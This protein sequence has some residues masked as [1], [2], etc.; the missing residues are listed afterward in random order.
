MSGM[1]GLGT[2]GSWTVRGPLFVAVLL[3]APSHLAH[4]DPLFEE[5][6]ERLGSPQPCFD[7]EH[8][9]AE[10]CYSSYVVAA[11]LNGDG[12]LDLLFANGGGYFVPA[13]AAPLAFYIN[14][15]HGLFTEAGA[16]S[17]GGFS[18]RVRQVAVGDIDGDG[19]LDVFV[20]DAFGMQAS[21]LFLNDG[22]R[23]P[24]FVDEAAARLPPHMRASAA[25]FG[26]VD[27]D[28]TLDLVVAE[29]GDTPPISPG[30]VRVFL[31][32]GRG[33]FREKPGAV[34]GTG[35]TAKPVGTGPVDL[36]LFDANDDFV[37]DILVAHR[38]GSS[39]LLLGD[40]TGSFRTD[41]SFPRQQGLYV[42]GP[43][44][45]DVDADGDLDIW[46]DNG[47]PNG[48]LALLI[49]D[50]HG[51]FTDETAERLTGNAGA[52]DDN[53]VR[54][55][56][57]N[58]DGA[59]DA[60]VGSVGSQRRV[61]QNDGHGHFSLQPSGF[62]VQQVSTLGLDIGDFDGDHRL[63][64]VTAQGEKG[65]FLNRLYLGG[66]IVAKDERPP[67]VRALERLPADTP[68]GDV[69]VHFAVSDAETTDVGPR[70]KEATLE[71]DGTP[72]RARFVGGDLFRAKVHIG[73]GPVSYRACATDA[74]GN[75][76]CG[77]AVMFTPRR[78]RSALIVISA[79]ALGVLLGVAFARRRLV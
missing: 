48:S 79:L 20:P 6:T 22:Q 46:L 56:D 14:D 12:A 37:L 28:G 23:S 30:I 16:A 55:A 66:A 11:D 41:P 64:V 42:Y 34:M 72:T 43:D 40:G 17:F 31:N 59:L 75:H 65:P 57:V 4:G 69:F 54:C 15:G 68:S 39:E 78:S 19:D 71:V 36:D 24:R 7:A 63:D 45:C 10:G 49:N 47:G 26:D 50:G 51:H 1:S 9:R 44:E 76:A 52:V 13:T 35:G 70:L 62:P 8:P 38:K 53:V 77:D 21:A 60:V 32:D 74:A 18:G 27:G 2:H 67:V 29:W 25:R 61:F 5:H 33:Y 73:D 3:V 58:G